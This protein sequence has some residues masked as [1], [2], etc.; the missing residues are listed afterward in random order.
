MNRWHER[1]SALTLLLV[2]L[3]GGVAAQDRS[4]VL[5]FAIPGHGSLKLQ[6]PEGWRVVSKSLQQ[7]AS[8][9]LRLGPSSG[10][11][12]SLQVTGVWLDSEKLAKATS[13]KMKADTTRAAEGPL[14]QAVEKAVT[15]QELRGAE[16]AG[17]YFSLTDRAPPARR[18]Q[19]PD[20]GY[21][22]HG[23]DHGR[24][25]VPAPRNAES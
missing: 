11:A 18:V 9:Q 4:G 19:V 8:L 25:H 22:P 23:G 13:E 7:P 24:V 20:P 16:T 1:A 6:V 3:A 17:Y 14:Q 21:R 10:D 2:V 12:F 15:V 5:P